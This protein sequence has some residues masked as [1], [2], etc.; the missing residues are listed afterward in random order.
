MQLLTTGNAA[1]V[2]RDEPITVSSSALGEPL[3]EFAPD[4]VNKYN[5]AYYQCRKAFADLPTL[6]TSNGLIGRSFGMRIA[7]IRFRA[8]K[9]RALEVGAGPKALTRWG[10]VADGLRGDQTIQLTLTDIAPEILPARA[11]S[12]PRI[13]WSTDCLD[14][15][16]SIVPC[17]D[18][19]RHDILVA[20]NSF[21]SIWLPGDVAAVKADGKWFT[22]LY[23]IV[24]P[25]THPHRETMRAA[26]RGECTSA[27]PSDF[28][29]LLIE[30]HLIPFCRDESPEV[31]DLLQR[32]AR[33]EDAATISVPLGLVR[34]IAEAYTTILRP[35]ATVLIADVGTFNSKETLVSGLMHHGI[36]ARY[37][38]IDFLMAK[39]LLEVRGFRVEV[40]S[41]E[42]FVAKSLGPN[43][44]SRG[45]LAEVDE[46]QSPYQYVMI[47]RPPG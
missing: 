45:N 12:N 18:R 25:N 31:Y 28:E 46:V 32:R 43:Y 37:K 33:N 29:R 39:E 17:P 15:T 2:R 26:F 6:Y 4:S 36:A 13:V 42:R 35:N 38:S 7:E 11:H 47:V 21:D 40:E 19:K 27:V 8:G 23:R 14:L 9:L 5:L 1:P 3:T 24:L 41:L 34:W 10:H 44:K 30:K 16:K 20:T 22:R